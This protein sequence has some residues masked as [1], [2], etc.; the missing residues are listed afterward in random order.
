MSN[1]TPLAFSSKAPGERVRLRFNF[2]RLTANPTNP[3]VTITQLSGPADSNTNDMK[4][5]VAAIATTRALQ[6]VV[7]G[8]DGADY[9]V[10]CTVDAGDEKYSL[11]GILPV[12]AR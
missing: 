6:L 2:A 4:S 10:E 8:L 3:V 12:R 1:S 7:A 11:Q 5:G 9:L